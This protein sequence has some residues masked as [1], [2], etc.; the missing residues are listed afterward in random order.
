MGR[1]G[2]RAWAECSRRQCCL[3]VP[4]EASRV[5]E[6]CSSVPQASRKPTTSLGLREAHKILL[7]TVYQWAYYPFRFGE[8]RNFFRAYLT[9]ELV[10]SIFGLVMERLTNPDGAVRPFS[11]GR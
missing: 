8:H 2:F 5:A 7:P 1:P 6:S 3:F 9:K 4:L 11:T 10:L